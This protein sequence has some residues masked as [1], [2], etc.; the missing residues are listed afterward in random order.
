MYQ[1]LLR[2]LCLAKPALDDL[3]SG[4]ASVA[5]A[6]A[7]PVRK[8]N[9]GIIPY[10]PASALEDYNDWVKQTLDLE[11]QHYIDPIVYVKHIDKSRPFYSYYHYCKECQGCREGTFLS[12]V[13][14]QQ[15]IPCVMCFLYR[16]KKMLPCADNKL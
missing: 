14:K 4:A 9:K 7:A 5:V 12:T 15:R 8:K 16:E 13:V 10:I 1:R 2:W 3:P 6:P 11:G